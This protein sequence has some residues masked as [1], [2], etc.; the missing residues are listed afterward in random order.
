MNLI[1]YVVFVCLWPT[2]L[3]SLSAAVQCL[4][5]RGRLCLR[6]PRLHEC[7]CWSPPFPP[8]SLAKQE[9]LLL[10]KR[11]KS[12]WSFKRHGITLSAKSCSVR[13]WDFRGKSSLCSWVLYVYLQSFSFVDVCVYFRTTSSSRP[14]CERNLCGIVP[15]YLG[16]TRE[17]NMAKNVFS[18]LVLPILYNLSCE[19]KKSTGRMVWKCLV[20]DMIPGSF[21]NLLPWWMKSY[22][23]AFH[24]FIWQMALN[25]LFYFIW[26]FVKTHQ[27]YNKSVSSI[28]LA[29]F[30]MLSPS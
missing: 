9:Q 28:I 13:R 14:V 3:F 16:K 27:I 21:M 11:K 5:L 22:L 8:S 19:W 20:K 2:S 23:I 1:F 29:R 24:D 4:P 17:L 26:H 12:S 6:W 15:C 18:L 10:G 7:K 25:N 30:A